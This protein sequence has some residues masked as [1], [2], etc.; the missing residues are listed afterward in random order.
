MDDLENPNGVTIEFVDGSEMDALFATRKP[1]SAWVFAPRVV[2]IDTEAVREAAPKM[3]GISEFSIFHTFNE[4]EERH[5]IEGVDIGIVELDK[6]LLNQDQIKSINAEAHSPINNLVIAHQK[7]SD[8]LTLDHI[9]TREVTEIHDE[10][11][12]LERQEHLQ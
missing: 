8:L 9:Y 2:H 4:S 11:A 1:S 10:T 3:G 5:N 7:G 6:P 12:Y